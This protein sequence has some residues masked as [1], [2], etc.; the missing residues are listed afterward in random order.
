[1]FVHM[2]NMFV[3]RLEMNDEHYVC[4]TLQRT[5]SEILDKGNLKKFSLAPFACSKPA[6]SS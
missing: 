2:F 6:S 3:L 4:S 1:M 5:F